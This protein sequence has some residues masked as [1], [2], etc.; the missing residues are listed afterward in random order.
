MDED[1][2][3]AL[4]APLLPLGPSECHASLPVSP[5]AVPCICTLSSVQTIHWRAA[6]YASAERWKGSRC[7]GDEK[8]FKDLKMSGRGISCTER[9]AIGPYRYH[10]SML[11]FALDFCKHRWDICT[12]FSVYYSPFHS[13]LFYCTTYIL[14]IFDCSVNL[15]LHFLILSTES[16]V[17]APHIIF[18]IFPH[19]RCS[20]RWKRTNCFFLLILW[21]SK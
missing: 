11:S 2:R 9:H 8:D 14:T 3:L 7:K 4:P 12:K 17:S 18:I 19:K 16:Q 21:W 20:Q 15:F 10:E 1:V 13:A 5:E 6:L